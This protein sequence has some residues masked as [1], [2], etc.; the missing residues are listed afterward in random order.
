MAEPSP[1]SASAAATRAL[2]SEVRCLLF[3]F[4]G[5]ISGQFAPLRPAKVAFDRWIRFPGPLQAVG[6]HEDDST[7]KLLQSPRMIVIVLHPMVP[8]RS[9]KLLRHR[10]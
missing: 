10:R 6:F 3:R 5:L 7:V 1:L 8:Q 9:C 2:N 4:I